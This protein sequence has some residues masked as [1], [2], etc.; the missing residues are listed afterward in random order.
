M[1]L[2]CILI[3]VAIYMYDMIYNFSFYYIDNIKMY[4][5]RSSIAFIIYIILY[6][7]YYIIYIFNDNSFADK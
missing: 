4:Y 1:L 5:N 6:N 3:F 2:Y 7:I